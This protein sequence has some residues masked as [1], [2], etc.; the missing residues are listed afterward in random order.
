MLSALAATPSTVADSPL[1][2]SR[3]TFEGAKINNIFWS[4]KFLARFVAI[5][6]GNY[7]HCTQPLRG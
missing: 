7:D 2:V 3:H 5:V 4:M 1:R 6:L